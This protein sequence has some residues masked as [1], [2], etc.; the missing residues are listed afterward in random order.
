MKKF[1]VTTTCAATLALGVLA[2]DLLR[3]QTAEANPPTFF[4]ITCVFPPPASSTVDRVNGVNVRTR[5]A[6]KVR[7]CIKAGGSP[8]VSTVHFAH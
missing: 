2:T 3:P 6:E 5:I 4:D 7:D 8:R 1:I